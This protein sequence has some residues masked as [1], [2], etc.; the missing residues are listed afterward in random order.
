ME[1][2]LLGEPIKLTVIDGLVKKI[3]GGREARLLQR[4]LKE[5]DDE[6]SYRFDEFS[7][8]FNNKARMMGAALEDKMM[9]GATHMALGN[10]TLRQKVLE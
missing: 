3:D 6:Y 2:G 5:K 7:M 9:Y 8:G 1:I 4:F 10:A